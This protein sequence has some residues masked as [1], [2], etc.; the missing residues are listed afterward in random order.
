MAIVAIT[1]L[2]FGAMTTER[3]RAESELRGAYEQMEAR[4]EDRTADLARTNRALTAVIEGHRHTLEQLRRRDRQFAEAQALAHIGSWEW[5]MVTDTVTWSDEL[6]RLYGLEPQSIQVDYA[7]FLER[8]HEADREVVRASVGKAHTEGSAFAHDHR[9]LWPDG[10]IHWLHGQGRVIWDAEGKPIAMAG[11]AQDVSRR[12]EHEQELLGARAELEIRVAERTDALR[13]ANRTKDEFLA[14]LAHE[15]RNPLAPIRNAVEAMRLEE[16]RAPGFAHLLAIVERQ[17]ENIV[18]LID[19]LL[20]I[21]RVEHGKV[22]LQVRTLDLSDAV[23]RAIETCAPVIREHDHALEMAFPGD[24]ILVAGDPLRLEQ[25]IVNLLTNAIKYTPDGGTIR[26]TVERLDDRAVFRVRDNGVGIEPAMLTHV[27]DLFV[28]AEQGLDRSR[29]GLGIGLTLV[30]RLV[31]L[32]GGSVSAASEGAG[33]G[34]EFVVTLPLA[35]ARPEP[36]RNG[37]PGAPG[38]ADKVRMN[39]ASRRV[40]VIEDHPEN[41]DTLEQLLSLAGHDVRVA[42]D[43]PEGVRLAL[44]ARPEVVLIDIG[45]PGMDGYEVCA[46]LVRELQQPARLIALTGYGDSE[47][48]ARAQAAGFDLVLA[49]PVPF[50]RLKEALNG[51]AE[52]GSGA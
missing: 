30:R 44:A 3:N 41:R 51:H 39:G 5:N 25:V 36:S 7:G 8:V 50:A 11:T 48:R 20:D 9:V 29:G 31:E 43:G 33:R 15:L 45:L 14:T 35:V 1:G 34:S 17:V 47:S 46:A 13:M 21:S 28:Q 19:E 24:P 22:D 37:R 52:N 2:V 42:A 18:R 38:E 49:K 16:H 10:S 6:F 4:V 40:L 23:R 12:R 26:L 27:F 32:H